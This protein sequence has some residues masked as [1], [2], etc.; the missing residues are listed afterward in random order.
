MSDSDDS[1][2]EPDWTEPEWT[3]PDD[4]PAPWRARRTRTPVEPEQGRMAAL[5]AVVAAVVV[6]GVIGAVVGPS[7]PAPAPSVADGVAV[8]PVGSYSASAFCSA[9]TGT[10][11]TTTIYL[12]NA[13][14][15]VVSG[16]MTSVGPVAAGGAVPTV[17][18]AVSVPALGSVAVN[19][20]DGL[21]AGSNATTFTFSG[22]GVVA[23]QAVAGPNGWSTAPCASQV[24]SQWSFAGGAT[25]AGNALGLSLY[26]PG[27]T[28][29][30]VNVSFITDN[31]FETPQQ[32]QGLVIPPGQ[33]V[34]E[35]VGD[36]VQNA[37]AIATLVVAQAG[38]VVSTEFQ[39]W[40]SGATGGMSLRLGSPQLSTIWRLAQ[41][42]ALPQS[43]VDL[44][45][46]NPGHAP[47]TATITLGLSSGT[48]VPQRVVVPPVAIVA[49]AASGTPG[50]PQQTPY[51][52]TVTASAPIVVG[53]S[54][55]AP[56]GSTPP[57]WGSSSATTTVATHW[58]V[59][60]PGIPTAPGAANAGVSSLA[61]ANSGSAAAQVE[62]TV[63]GATRPVAMFTVAPQEV[64]VLGPQQVGGLS[65]LTVSASQPVT[66]EEDS[67]PSGAPGVVSSTGFP[68]GR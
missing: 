3:V 47:V 50:L 34:E 66:V 23:S 24:A 22:G 1:L 57:V 60:A 14:Q 68:L 45:L 32:Y 44:Y 53:R 12:T 40:S 17:R 35:N 43:T 4:A 63:L 37:A 16:V 11:A 10:A 46:A 9:G 6:I 29:A 55:L 51:S 15:A 20:A 58:L 30:V 33:V 48:V 8:A 42:T 5:V 62:V 59:P 38:G 19:P 36:Y 27:A 21:P 49:F 26:N 13:T 64:V 25:T 54:V 39:Q 41:T 56:A 67:G 52:L 7:S 18:R 28:E 65:P 2:T 61:V 31:G